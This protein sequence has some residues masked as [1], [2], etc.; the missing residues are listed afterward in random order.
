MVKKISDDFVLVPENE[1]MSN[2]DW[3]ELMKTIYKSDALWVKIVKFIGLG[4]FIK[5]APEQDWEK[6][7][8]FHKAQAN[9][10]E[11]L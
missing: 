4:R 9:R 3:R 7:M 1:Q 11:Q 8:A 2:E 5:C 10:I 6:I